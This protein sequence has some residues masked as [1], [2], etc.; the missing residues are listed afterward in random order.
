MTPESNV[1]LQLLNERIEMRRTIFNTLC[2]GAGFMAL[3][4][5][6]VEHSIYITYTRMDTIKS[7]EH[8]SIDKTN[9]PLCVYT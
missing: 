5:A 8:N 9:V 3:Y 6:A 4:G 7:N 1:G 2:G